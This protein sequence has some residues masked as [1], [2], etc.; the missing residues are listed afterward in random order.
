MERSLNQEKKIAAIRIAEFANQDRA[1]AEQLGIRPNMPV[2]LHPVTH[3]VTAK[4]T[5]TTIKFVESS[6]NNTVGVQTFNS[7]KLDANKPLVLCGIAAVY[8]KEATADNKTVATASYDKTAPA[9]LVNGEIVLSQE[10]RGDLV[11]M[12]LSQAF[13]QNTTTHNL[14]REFEVADMP[15]IKDKSSF[16]LEAE[17]PAALASGSDHFVRVELRGYT[18]QA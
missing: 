18:I 9:E 12:L 1:F 10:N 15:I 17:I 5:G 2:R 8:A 16:K 7:D 11:D 6:K 3:Y 4:V 13:N 14:E